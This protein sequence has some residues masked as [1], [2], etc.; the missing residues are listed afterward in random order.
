MRNILN[1]NTFFFIGVAGTG[2]SALAHYL[3]ECSKNVKGSDRYFGTPKEAEIRPQL[4]KVGVECFPQDASGLDETVNVV[5][6]S[7]AVEE[8]NVEYQRARQLGLPM[9]TRP[10]LLALIANE[11]RTIA[12]G[13]TAGKSTTTAMIFHILNYCGV[14]PS[15]INGAGLKSLQKQG[16]VGSAWVDKSDVMVIE[17]DESNGTII[18]YTPDIGV[19]LNMGRDH[20]EHDEL[21]DLFETF[22]RN[23]RSHFIVNADDSLVQELSNGSEHDFGCD[24]SAGFVARDYQADGFF[25]RFT[26]NNVPFCLHQGGQHN[27]MNA[28]A[29]VATV[30]KLGVTVEQSAKALESFEGVYRRLCLV[31]VKNGIA[32]VDDFAHNPNEVITAIKA[33][34]GMGQRVF[35]WFQPHGFGPLRFMRKDLAN[36]VCAT[37]RDDDVFLSSDVYYAGGTVAKDINSDSVTDDIVTQGKKAVFLADRNDIAS[38]CAANAQMGDVILVMGARDP[39]L[40]WFAEQVLDSLPET[41]T[42]KAQS[43]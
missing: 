38:Y 25:I 20:K 13:G 8:N 36:M 11:K 5:V 19:V 9:I 15:M 33:C 37:L 16:Y 39:S 42:A 23:T 22:K 26:I 35:A 32:V 1:H 30:S 40:A 24:D 29:A 10:E 3:A 2:M 28:A 12:V 31:G 4:E 43:V 17:A 14:E 34:Q 18:N 41:V 21:Y 27:M 6:Y 7:T